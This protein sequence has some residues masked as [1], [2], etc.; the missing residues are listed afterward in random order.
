M[1]VL[2]IRRKRL[3]SKYDSSL[4][5]QMPLGPGDITGMYRNSTFLWYS[6]MFILLKQSLLFQAGILRK[7]FVTEMV[8]DVTSLLSAH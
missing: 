6:F 1:L 8:Y 2:I 3:F 4:A 5:V 7:G